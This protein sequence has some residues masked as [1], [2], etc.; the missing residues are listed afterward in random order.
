MTTCF[1]TDDSTNF[2]VV[3]TAE[4]LPHETE[5]SQGRILV[6]EIVDRKLRLAAE[7]EVKGAVYTLKAFNGKLLAGINS[8]IELFRMAEAEGGGKELTTECS[9]RGHILVLY[10]EA[11]G[12]FILLGD[13]MRS[14]TLLTYKPVDGQA[15]SRTPNSRSGPQNEKPLSRCCSAPVQADE[16]EKARMRERKDGCG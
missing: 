9:H 3:G 10:L 5:P 16:G 11:K 7:K 6:F 13:L 8:K 15:I 14:M 2:I 12:D 4:A 1:F